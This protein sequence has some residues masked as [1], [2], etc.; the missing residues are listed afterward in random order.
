[1]K[2]RCLNPKNDEFH[3]YGAKGITVCE[4]WKNSFSDFLQ[5]MGE[6]PNGFQIDRINTSG[7]Y[8]PANCRWTSPKENSRNRHDARKITIEGITYHVLE[9]SDRSGL[10]ADTILNRAKTCTSLQ[11]LLDPNKR[12]WTVAPRRPPRPGWKIQCKQGH[13]YDEGNTYWT[14]DG[15]R[16]CRI[17]R[18]N[19]NK[20]RK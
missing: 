2:Q 5:D 10:K 1:M 8:E 6:C 9:L 14:P 7:N 16:Q 17:C 13:P 20:K 15:T 3:N 12:F 18:Y 11:E 19:Q 4:R